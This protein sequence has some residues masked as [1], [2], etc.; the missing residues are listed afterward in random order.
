MFKRFSWT[1]ASQNRN[2]LT[3][4]YEPLQPYL[5]LAGL[6]RLSSSIVFDIG[7]NIGQYSVFAASLPSVQK[8]FAF[9]AEQAA[10]TQ[11]SENISRNDRDG[12]IYATFAAV[13]DVDG[14]IVFGVAGPMAGNNAIVSTSI[15]DVHVFKER[16]SVPAI[17]LDSAFTLSNRALGFKIDVEGHEAAVINGAR[18]LLTSNACFIQVEIYNGQESLIE[19]M[20]KLGYTKLL[21]AGPDHY[22]SNIDMVQDAKSVVEMTEEAMEALINYNLNG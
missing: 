18:R 13:S 9:E 16:R 7:A 14:E 17:A 2:N 3:L 5:F 6:R 1:P 8:V 22:F 12:K 21:K 10:Y 11:L 19:D 4:R 15:H 20:T